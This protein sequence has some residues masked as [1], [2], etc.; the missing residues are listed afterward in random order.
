MKTLF[1]I[2]RI[3]ALS[4]ICSVFLVVG[5]WLYQTQAQQPKP[6][7][8]REVEVEIGADS[9]AEAKFTINRDVNING[10]LTV[11]D[12]VGIGTANPAGFFHVA[13]PSR[14][15][16]SYASVFFSPGLSNNGDWNEIMVGKSASA[17]Q[18]AHLRYT[19]GGGGAGTGFVNLSIRG[20]DNQLVVHGNGNVGI[21]TTDPA[22]PLHM[23]SGA[24][25]TA[26]G[27]WTN[28]SDKN[29]KENFAS[30]DGK[31]LLEK[32]DQLPISMWNYK[33]EGENVKHIG[34]TA[35]DFDAIF[36]LGNG[37]KAISTID[38]A[39]IALAAIQ[40]LKKRNDALESE[41][42]ALAAKNEALSARLEAL[43]VAVKSLTEK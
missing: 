19:Y 15:D 37:D 28:A 23:A 42:K 14:N 5:V 3:F 22:H 35:Q 29:L 6:G 38:P 11:R 30:V 32:I 31:E 34:P 10:A 41:N 8:E 39:G 21:G 16:D 2:N 17:W 27:V 7:K 36:G 9:K 40:E 13:M 26:G 12:N 25:V 43:E 24:H 18:G 33:A 1:R 4:M 20:L